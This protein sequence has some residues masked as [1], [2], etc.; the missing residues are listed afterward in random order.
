M[1][2]FDGTGPKGS[3]PMTGN[4]GGYCL[5][6]VPSA[7]GEPMLGL[8]G[9]EGKPVTIAS[10]SS[11]ERTLAHLKLKAVHIEN[12]LEHI[13]RRIDDLEAETDIQRAVL[14]E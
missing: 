10:F 6:K 1:P 14:N 3:G 8:A 11:R 4:A 9:R 7:P 5:L 2:G 13:R 12:S